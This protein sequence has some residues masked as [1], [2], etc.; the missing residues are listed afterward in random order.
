MPEMLRCFLSSFLDSR[1]GLQCKREAILGL[2]KDVFQALISSCEA[3]SC[4]SNIVIRAWPPNGRV[5][6]YSRVE[7]TDVVISYLSEADN[8]KDTARWVEEAWR[9]AILGRRHRGDLRRT[10]N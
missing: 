6:K 9:K 2:P 7:G 8:L 5:L 1:R 4:C 3:I 10:S